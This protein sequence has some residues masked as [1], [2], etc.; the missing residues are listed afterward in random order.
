M[1]LFQRTIQAIRSGELAARILFVFCNRDP[2]ESNGSDEFMAL[3]ASYD[4]PLITFSSNKFRERLAGS[5]RLEIR[6]QFDREVMRRIGAYD[7]DKCMLA[8][9][10]LIIGPEMCE[11]YCMLNLHPALPNGPI[12][13]WQNVIWKVIQDQHTHHGA[14]IHLA[15]PELDQGPA[16]SYVQ[17][18]IRGPV[19]EPLWLEINRQP[20]T[21]LRATIGEDLRLF[22]EI[23]HHGIQREQPL[24]IETLKAFA[25]GR[26]RIL[27]TSIFSFSDK[28]EGAICLNQEIERNLRS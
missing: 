27:G 2:G 20:I 1:E 22:Q 15:T 11:K 21:G 4:I 18:P 14:T 13:T 12:G 24:L 16:L 25:T 10:M 8:G 6:T 26:L 19:F 9:Y 5:S 28:L 17:F 3:V 23:R 7:P